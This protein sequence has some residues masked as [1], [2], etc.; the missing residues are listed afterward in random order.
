[1]YP[2]LNIE[3]KNEEELD[4]L[5]ETLLQIKF[6]DNHKSIFKVRYRENSK[7]VNLIFNVN[8]EK[9]DYIYFKNKK[10]NVKDLGLEYGII[11]QGT[12]YHMP[13]GILLMQGKKSKFLFKNLYEVDTKDIFSYIMKIFGL[14]VE[15]KYIKSL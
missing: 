15:N 11:E 1:M 6:Q 3:S 9:S 5:I 13:E 7:M 14:K 10:I 12:G 8:S 4:I 2:D